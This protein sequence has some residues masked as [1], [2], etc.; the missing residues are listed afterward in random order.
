MPPQASPLPAILTLVVAMSAVPFMDAIAKHLSATL[1]VVQVTWA[2]YVFHLVLALPILFWT[3]RG[4][5]G[6]LVPKRIGLQLL[7]GV[8]LVCSTFTFF[9]SV[10]YLPLADALALAFVSPLVVTAVSPFL[11]GEHV[12]IRRFTAVGVGFIGALIIIR[13]GSGVMHWASLLALSAGV[14]Y[15]LYVV[16]TRKLAGSAPPIVTLVYG[17]LFGALVTSTALPFAWQPPTTSE[18]G[19]MV[20]IGMTAACTHY[21]LIRAY[22]GAPASLLQPFS[23]VE[24]IMATI[25]GYFWFGD[26]PDAWTGLGVAILIASG[27]YVSLRERQLHLKRDETSAPT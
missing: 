5:G 13:P 9:L 20:A 8:L 25:L 23:Y 1:P 19:W 21:L 24:I 12:G 2:R 3:Q 26:F 14:T 17:A 22:E 11:L 4:G 16:L 7:R 27:I 6:Q 15:A 10:K 18:W